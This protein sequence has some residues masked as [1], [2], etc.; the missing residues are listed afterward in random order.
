MGSVCG[1]L[2]DTIR[3]FPDP[4]PGQVRGTA[5]CC[6]DAGLLLCGAS[7]SGKSSIALQMM[8]FGAQLIS[9]DIVWLD[10]KSD[11]LWIS[12]PPGVTGPLQIEARCFGILDAKGATGARL[13]CI[14]DLDTVE[15]E[16]L[17]DRKALALGTFRVPLFHKVATSVFPA[18]LWQYLQGMNELVES[19]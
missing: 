15:H 16:R 13:S 10:E 14:V 1:M 7:G 12:R 4:F 5:V 9:D 18:M 8:A 3:F 19:T 2:A 17:P 11:A 6:G